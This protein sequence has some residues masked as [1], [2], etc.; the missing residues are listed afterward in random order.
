MRIV[1]VTDCYLPRMGGIETQVADLVRHQSAA[2]H[3]VHVVTSTIED[4]DPNGQVHRIRAGWIRETMLRSLRT[5]QTV[6]RLRPDVVHCHNSVLSPLAVAVAGG[7]SEL[8][9]PTAVT[10]HSLL[11]A[12]GPV[13]PLSGHVLG[14][15]NLRLAWSAVSEVAAGPVRRVLG[16]ATQVDVLPNAVDVGWWRAA[17]ATRRSPITN[18]VRIVSVGRMAVRKRP[19]ALL[20]I[21]AEVRDIVRVDVPLRLV[22]VGDGPQ[23]RQVARRI[24][25][26]GMSDW[27]DVHGQ[28]PRWQ[29]RDVLAAA[30]LYVAPATLESFGIAALEAR[31]VGL[32]VVA[33]DRG[34]VGE[35]VTNG[36]DGILATTDRDMA[37]A[38]ARLAESTT[39]REGIR[40]H[41]C[42]VAPA[43]GWAEALER[44]DQL[45]ARAADLVGRSD[46]F[47]RPVPALTA[48]DLQ[49]AR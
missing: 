17:A 13:L 3:D 44:T 36:T 42:A 49:V 28:L 8:G 46:G 20:R 16:G 40:A 12:V 24:R 19:L 4:A 25:D 32:P 31:A 41:N 7:A 6:G 35:F 26:L 18:E 22:L 23:R 5:V 34:G 38:L 9:I 14:V 11:P 27:V 1:H 10:V 45:Y 48:A 21:M 39:L 29:I 15:R 43:F 33:K 47:R 2:G 30:D 37:R